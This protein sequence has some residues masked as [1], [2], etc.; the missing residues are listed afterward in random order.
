MS[1]SAPPRSSVLARPRWALWLPRWATA[2]EGVHRLIIAASLFLPLFVLA[3]GGYLGWRAEVAHARTDLSQSVDLVREN[4]T[5][6]F[7][8]YQLLLR[9]AAAAVADA[10]DAEILAHEQQLHERL[11]SIL[12]Q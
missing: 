1:A 4:T 9:A 7:E 10:P 12:G 2:T 11:A 5:R 8:T 3:G 6:V